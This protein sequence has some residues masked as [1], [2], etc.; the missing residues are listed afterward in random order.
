MAL[1]WRGARFAKRPEALPAAR[2]HHAPL[3]PATT[4]SRLGDGIAE[5]AT[6]RKSS[7]AGVGPV[8]VDAHHDLRD[9]ATQ[10]GSHVAPPCSRRLPGAQTSPALR[11]AVLA[12]TQCGIRESALEHAAARATE[13]HE[14]GVQCALPARTAELSS[15]LREHRPRPRRRCGGRTGPAYEEHPTSRT[16]R[17]S[18]AVTRVAHSE[19]PSTGTAAS[20]RR[21]IAAD[22]VRGDRIRDARPERH[23]HREQ[24]SNHRPCRPAP[25]T[26]GLRRRHA[27][28]DGGSMATRT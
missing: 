14:Q 11:G 15:T 8:R 9:S 18:P 26:E 1:I 23:G 6:A 24:S 7:L 22:G 27:E 20:G 25:R 19:R 16:R 3:R 4:R 5:C 10:N 13:Q 12:R 2:M 21:S 28:G 17:R